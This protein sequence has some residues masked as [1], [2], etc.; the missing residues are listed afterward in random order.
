MTPKDRQRLTVGSVFVPGGLPTVTYNPRRDLR[1]EERVTDYLDE[2]HKILSLSG[3]TKTGKTVLLRSLLDDPIWL[4]GGAIESMGAFWGVVSDKLAI[5]TELGVDDS[6]EDSDS[7]SWQAGGGIKVVEGHRA[8]SSQTSTGRTNRRSRSRPADAA[9]REALMGALRPL[10]VDDFHYMATDLQ[11]SVVRNL[12]ELVFDGLPVI[13][14]AVPHRAYDAVRV[15]KEMTGRVEQLQIPFW[16]KDELLGI[17]AAGFDA[18]NATDAHGV[19]SRLADESF[20]SPHLMQ[21]FCR[22]VCKANGVRETADSPAS[23]EPPPDWTPFFQSRASAAS[24]TAFDLLTR[25]PRQRTDRKERHLKDGRVTDIYGLVLA[26]IAHTGPLTQLTYEE[27]R[28]ALREITRGD[29]PQRHEIT[30]VL[31]EMSRIAREQIEG[32]PVLDYD[33]ELSTLFISDPFFA[34]FLRWGSTGENQ[35]D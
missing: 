35:P 17:A 26:A 1:L 18:L 14:A 24:K 11:L 30:R 22:E 31:E 10:V 27:L 28:T 21:E 13:F 23:L 2:R 29:A 32:E 19:S 3:P 5:Y 9:A 33:V 7:R 15:E 4:S 34:Y 8:G 6:S 20:S 16:E 25:G 12:K